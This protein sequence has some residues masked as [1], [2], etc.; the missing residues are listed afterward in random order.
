MRPIT[1]ASKPRPKNAPHDIPSAMSATSNSRT[2]KAITPSAAT[3]PAGLAP[4]LVVAGGFDEELTS[5]DFVRTLT[6][7]TTR[8]TPRINAAQR[9]DPGRRA[10]YFFKTHHSASARIA[11]SKTLAI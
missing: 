6:A 2:Q 4:S 5:G 3:K 11:A 9:F 8:I 10:S 1:T 7:P